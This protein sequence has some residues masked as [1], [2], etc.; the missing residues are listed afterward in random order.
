LVSLY[1]VSLSGAERPESEVNHSD[2]SSGKVKSECISTF[3]PFI[4]LHDVDRDNFII[5]FTKLTASAKDKV[6]TVAQPV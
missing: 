6:T 2:P 5:T 4:R 3:S 1:R